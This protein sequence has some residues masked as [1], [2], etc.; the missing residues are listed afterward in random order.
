MSIVNATYINK[1]IETMI[2]DEYEHILVDTE[3]SENVNDSN[4][5]N[6]SNDISGFSSD[7]E[8]IKGV[9]G[10]GCSNGNFCNHSIT[11]ED[12]FRQL[13]LIDSLY[14]T[15]IQRMRAYGI[16]EIAEDI[17]KLCGNGS[18]KHTLGTLTHKI[19]IT[20]PLH[21]NIASIFTKNYGWIKGE[22]NWS[23]PSLI[24]KYL[25]FATIVYPRNKWGFPIFDTI[26]CDLLRSMQKRLSIPLTPTKN[27]SL[28]NGVLDINIYIDGLKRIIDALE[29]DNPTLWS[30]VSMTKFQL[31]DHFLWHIGKAGRKSY[32]LLLT[33]SEIKNCYKGRKLIRLPQRILIWEQIYNSIK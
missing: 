20:K 22:R 28:V 27:F 30:S 31:L 9:F 13:V 33:K 14:S 23:A 25:F 18:G 15:N 1:C 29:T 3:G 10:N 2:N 17:Y 8:A 21:H 7:Y 4:E 19:D 6:E 12:I 16:D 32:N 5:N 11:K 24:S 26:V